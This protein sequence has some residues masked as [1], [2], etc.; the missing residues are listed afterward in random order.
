MARLFQPSV[1]WI[2][3]AEKNFYKKVPKEEKEVRERGQVQWARGTP[4]QTSGMSPGRLL[5][6]FLTLEVGLTATPV[7]PSE[8]T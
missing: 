4:L 7:C 8:S 2:G 3:N 5:P 6:H 1:I